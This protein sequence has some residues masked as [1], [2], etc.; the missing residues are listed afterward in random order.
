MGA[1]QSRRNSNASNRRGNAANGPPGNSTG[2]GGG[3]GG[4]PGVAQNQQQQQQ[5]PPQYVQYWQAGQQPPPQT[6]QQ[7]QQQPTQQQQQYQHQQ[8]NGQQALYYMQNTQ[9]N[10]RYVPSPYPAPFVPTPYVPYQGNVQQHQYP[11]QHQ[12]PPT[13]PPQHHHQPIEPQRT[14]TIRN[15]VNLKKP[16]LAIAPVE[17]KTDTLRLTFTLDATSPCTATVFWGVSELREEKNKLMCPMPPLKRVHFEKGL[18]QVYSAPENEL[19]RLS[20][21][22]GGGALCTH[23]EQMAS[24]PLVIRLETL[25]QAGRDAGHS[26]DELS[27]GC[28]LQ[29]W[30][31]SQTTYCELVRTP[32]QPT[33]TWG[34]RVIKQKIWVNE[35][36]YELQDIYGIESQSCA[37]KDGTSSDSG[38]IDTGDDAGRECVICMSEPRDT[39]VLPCRH[40]CMCAPCAKA[41]REQTNK[42]PICRR[43]VESLLKIVVQQSSSAK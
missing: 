34:I 14:Q 20:D 26:L 5:P 33:D 36:S 13:M 10:Q 23:N 22:E 19:L 42:C 6:Q 4:Y 35:V 9:Q 12:A 31:Q 3:G 37:A 38:A 8:S 7:L 27:P 2:G 29:P 16:S 32:G 17:G 39:A 25:T 15:Q 18:G 21:Y 24:Y 41:L 28:P 1:G 30:V 40:M 43:Q 11:M